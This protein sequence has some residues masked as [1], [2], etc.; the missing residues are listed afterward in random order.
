VAG[1]ID[2]AQYSY[3]V[4][5]QP[6]TPSEEVAMFRTIVL[7]YDGTPASGHAF[8]Q[9]LELARQAHQPL[10]VVAVAWSS[11]VETHV[12][13]DQERVRCW[14]YLQALRDRE[15]A[16]GVG[17]ELEVVDG[18]PSE[19]I[20]AAADRVGAD[21]LVIGHRRRSLLRRMAQASVAKRVI[22]HAH[23]PVMVAS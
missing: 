23:C 20:V 22:D 18:I 8:V 5:R 15:A 14:G 9:A 3:T 6:S 13:L 4:Q 19:Q 11:E 16:A 17:L 1:V 2:E 12:A 21:L 7:A 10:H